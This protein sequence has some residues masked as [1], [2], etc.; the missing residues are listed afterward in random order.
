MHN[1]QAAIIKGAKKAETW[2]QK[3]YD[4]E[5]VTWIPHKTVYMKE[6]LICRGIYILLYR[7][8]F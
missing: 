8:L 1:I 7:H 4:R 5:K 6:F 3:W 2:R